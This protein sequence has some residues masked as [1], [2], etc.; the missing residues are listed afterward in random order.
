MQ[1]SSIGNTLGHEETGTD[2]SVDVLPLRNLL[3]SLVILTKPRLAFFSL[4]SAAA[5]YG[6]TVDALVLSH[7]LLT[8]MG[9]ALAAGGALSFNHW[10]ERGTDGLMRR[11]C[12][13]PLPAGDLNAPLALLW[14]VFLSVSGTG[15][16]WT[17]AGWQSALLAAATIF[18][19]G[20][21]YTPMKRRSPWATEVGSLSGALPPLIGSAAAGNTFSLP[22]I[23][24][25][26]I[27][28]FWQM[29]H[30]YAI[31]W[32]HREDY[33]RAGFPLLPAIDS[34]G[35][36][37]ARW[38]MIYS[39][40]LLAWT[41][42]PWML[43]WAGWIYGVVSVLAGGWMVYRSCL[44]CFQVES[45]ERAARRLFIATL[46]HLPPVMTALLVDASFR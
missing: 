24:L 34:T 36:R 38:S 32:L 22:G 17:V 11:T 29:P 31:G 6:S 18:I 13:R 21:L 37:T 8:M 12:T 33:R 16:L 45:N 46:V 43:G 41:L 28:L 44:F 20:L 19:Y 10:W 1:Q 9:V 7:F 39:L 23:I 2:E 30:F 14:S 3:R 15:L 5:A 42:V 40:L 26:G 35:K 4:M 25:F 27:I